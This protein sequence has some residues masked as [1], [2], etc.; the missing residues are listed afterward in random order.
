MQINPRKNMQ[1]SELLQKRRGNKTAQYNS[2][3][4]LGRSRCFAHQKTLN[5]NH[6]KQIVPGW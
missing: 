5:L 4:N 6:R 2:I 1:T 3:Q